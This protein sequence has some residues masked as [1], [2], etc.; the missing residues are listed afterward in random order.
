MT[1]PSIEAGRVLLGTEHAFSGSYPNER[2]I[3]CGQWKEGSGP[4]CSPRP[5]NINDWN[6]AMKW[7]DW[8]VEE[9]GRDNFITNLCLSLG[10]ARCSGAMLKSITDAQPKHYIMAAM[11]LNEQESKNNE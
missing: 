7:R 6:E 1:D 5:I 11:R 10:F 8:A 2:C 9:Y 4:K 3:K